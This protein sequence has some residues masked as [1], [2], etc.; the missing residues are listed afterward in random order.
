MATLSAQPTG[1]SI[2]KS[3]AE[4]IQSF[5]GF[6]LALSEE[7]C[8]VLRLEQVELSQVLEEY[9]RTN[10][11]GDQTKAALPARARGSLDDTIRHDTELSLVQG[12]VTRLRL[13]LNHGKSNAADQ[14]FL[15]N[16]VLQQ[17]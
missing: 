4:Y 9:G 11:W 13:L 3:Y 5:L 12:I 1:R 16:Y 15:S 6:V 2:S 8:R 14:R 10:V 17:R 7:D